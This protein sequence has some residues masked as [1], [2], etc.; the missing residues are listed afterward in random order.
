MQI[1]S[2]LQVFQIT[3]DKLT[4]LPH[5]AGSPSF[6]GLRADDQAG[7]RLLFCGRI[8][9]SDFQAAGHLVTYLVVLDGDV[10]DLNAE[11]KRTH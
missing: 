2:L 4:L 9:M 11:I 10:L 8:E 3:V 6:Q 7:H 1:T 5:P